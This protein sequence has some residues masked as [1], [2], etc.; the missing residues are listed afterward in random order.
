VK[1]GDVIH[2]GSVHQHN[3]NSPLAGDGAE[4]SGR[5]RWENF[6]WRLWDAAAE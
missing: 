1:E 4:E 3:L 6:P 2:G 5:L